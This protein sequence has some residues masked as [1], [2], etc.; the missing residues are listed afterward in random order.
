LAHYSWS[1]HCRNMEQGQYK[2]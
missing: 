1:Y 2:F